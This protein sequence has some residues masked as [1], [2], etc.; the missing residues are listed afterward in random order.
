[1]LDSK[2]KDGLHRFATF[3]SV[4]KCFCPIPKPRHPHHRYSAASATYGRNRCRLVL[5]AAQIDR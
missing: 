3:R 4:S 5:L 1:M 2:G